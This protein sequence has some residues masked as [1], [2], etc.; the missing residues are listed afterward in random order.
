[1]ALDIETTP[2]SHV[3]STGIRGLDA[4]LAGGIPR[5]RLFLI[6]GDPGVGKTTLALSFLLAG[7]D[8]GERGLYVTLSESPDEL[9]AVARSHGWDLGGIDVHELRPTDLLQGDENTLFHPAEVELQEATQELQG[10][11]ERVRPQRV[12]FDSL[13]ELRLLAQSPHRYRRLILTLKQ[14]FVERGCTV[15]LLDDREQAEAD[16]HLQ[17]IAHG[18]L[19]LEQLAPL[20][21]AERRRLRVMK[22]RGVRFRGGYHDYKIRTGGLDVFPRLV[23]AEHAGAHPGE[24]A[25]SGIAALDALFGGGIHRGT[26]TLIMGPPGTGKSVVATQYAVAAAERGERAVLFLFDEQ[27]STLTER[28]EAMK[29]GLTEQ[30]RRG[31]ISL[32]AV[33]PAELPPGEFA[34]VVVREVEEKG[35]RVIVID[36]LNGYFSAMPEE[37]FLTLQMHELLTYLAQQGVVTLLVVAQHGVFGDRA[38]FDVSYLADS[39]ILLRN[40]E[41]RGRLRKSL[42]VVKKRSGPHENTIHELTL[43]PGGLSLGAPLEDLHGILTGTPLAVGSSAFRVDGVPEPA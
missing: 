42:S 20:Y 8:A 40:F 11:F 34:S 17:T 32:A 39:V 9:V 7:R 18:V 28:S 5:E 41:S 4:I 19:T 36:S 29:M 26:S 22:V 1:M 38:I 43:G 16:V 25:S 13:A 30:I 33:D 2:S 21:G 12:V 35:A 23:A 14:M 31:H 27:P 10:L 37:S 24:G 6:Q 3:A 15:V